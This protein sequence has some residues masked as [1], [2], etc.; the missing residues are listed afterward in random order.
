MDESEQ[1]AGLDSGIIFN[2][3]QFS[4]FDGPGIRTAVFMKGC[5]LRCAWCHNPESISYQP[6]LSFNPGKCIGCGKC[7]EACPKKAHVIIN[8]D[9][10][11]DRSLCSRCF[12]CVDVCYAEALTAIGKEMTA[13][14]VMSVILADKP[15][16]DSSGGG[17]TF[18]GGE[19]M[20][21]PRFLKKLLSACKEAGVSTAIDTA[22]NVP[23]AAFE[24][25]NP[26]VDIYLYD[27]KAVDEVLHKALT[28]VSNR[29][30][31]DN[32]IR[33]LRDG[34]RV[35]VRIPYIPGGNTQDMEN[36]ACF[37]RDH[38]S[39]EAEL[40]AYHRLGESKI[41]L[42]GLPA[43][44]TARFTVPEKE[45]VRRAVELFREKGV[46]CTANSL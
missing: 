28:G 4:L 35:I 18:S 24:A 8:G 26:N 31:L 37:L 1:A 20:T 10:S 38:Y 29:L 21:R 42:I 2:I 45:E 19:A 16:Y 43:D 40:L 23:Y 22:G 11:V 15:Y 12:R 17:V 41:K 46:N 9:H 36:I 30:I 6:E 44:G 25:I 13:E 7:F 34:K 3:Q 33:L 27:I 14:E 5:N 39:G 32:F